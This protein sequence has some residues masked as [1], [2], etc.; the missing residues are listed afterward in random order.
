MPI[1]KLYRGFRSIVYNVGYTARE[2][3]TGKEAMFFSP[4]LD[5]PALVGPVEQIGKIREA[6]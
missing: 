3:R 2:N 4:H 5:I 1:R 6:A